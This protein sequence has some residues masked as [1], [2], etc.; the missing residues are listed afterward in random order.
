MKKWVIS[1]VVYLLVVVG[2]YYAVTG[3]SEA[4]SDGSEHNN[5]ELHGE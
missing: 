1:A 2:G 4:P 3:F 5:T